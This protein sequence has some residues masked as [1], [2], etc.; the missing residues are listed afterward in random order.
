MNYENN[1]I[2]FLT[3]DSA[4]ANQ[5]LKFADI[6]FLVKTCQAL[7]DSIVSLSESKCL[8]QPLQA[9][10]SKLPRPSGNSKLVYSSDSSATQSSSV[11]ILFGIFLA[12]MR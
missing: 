5:L 1:S 8:F 9:E 7:I 10:G 12:A 6:Q 2:L 3:G 11:L 4:S